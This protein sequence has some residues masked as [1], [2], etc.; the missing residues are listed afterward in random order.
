MEAIGSVRT[1]VLLRGADRLCRDLR[2]EQGAVA[3]MFALAVVPLTFAVG[4]GGDQQGVTPRH[5]CAGTSRAYVAND[6]S[7]LIGVFQQIAQTLGALKL[8]R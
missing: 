4:A 3:V 7:A 2:D 1:R 6:A 5:A 8:T